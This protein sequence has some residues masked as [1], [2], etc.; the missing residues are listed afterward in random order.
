M[1]SQLTM[2][3]A[4]TAARL[5]VEDGLDWGSAKRRALRELGLPARTALPD[6]EVL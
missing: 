2:E 3:I 4:Q 6:N 5:V 1:P